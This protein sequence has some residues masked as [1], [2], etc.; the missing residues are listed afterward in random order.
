MVKKS[1]IKAMYLNRVRDREKLL[2]EYNELLDAY[3]ENCLASLQ[4]DI[5]DTERRLTALDNE[6]SLLHHI[7]GDDTPHLSF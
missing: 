6:I 2:E 4:D 7:L 1:A 5:Q 3:I